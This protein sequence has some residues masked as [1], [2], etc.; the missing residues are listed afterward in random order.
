MIKPYGTMT[1]EQLNNGRGKRRVIKVWDREK[2]GI[3]G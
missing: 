1:K 3:K 2:E